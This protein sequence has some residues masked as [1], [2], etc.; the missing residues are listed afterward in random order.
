MLVGTKEGRKESQNPA[1]NQEA[2]GGLSPGAPQ[3]STAAGLALAP[4]GPPGCG[5]KA[6]PDTHPAF[7]AKETQ[8]RGKN[9]SSVFEGGGQQL[10]DANTSQ[11]VPEPG[12]RI[13]LR[14]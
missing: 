14:K 10:L 8:R 3:E 11:E 6:G 7:C 12:W 5:A 1:R 9:T 2:V 13:S 4:P